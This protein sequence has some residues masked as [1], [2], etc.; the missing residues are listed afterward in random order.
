[1]HSPPVIDV[2]H[3]TNISHGSLFEVLVEMNDADGIDASCGI[4]YLQNDVVI[5]NRPDSVVSDLDGT[6]VW[7]TSWLLP[8]GLSGNLTVDISCADWSENYA[9]YSSQIKVSNATECISDCDSLE[10]ESE[11]AAESNAV[12]LI[13]GLLILAIIITLVITRVRAR[14]G[15]EVTETWQMDEQTPESDSRI[16]E[17]WTLDEFLDWLDGPMPEGWEEEQWS[18]YRESLEDLR[19]T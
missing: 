18:Q 19:L 15:E 17:G 11:E 6:G 8:T 13:S 9:N 3:E 10:Q 12:A 4:S 5:Y 14:E 2:T 16:P 7:S 1:M